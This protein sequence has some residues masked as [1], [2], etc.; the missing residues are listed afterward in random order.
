MHQVESIVNV[1]ASLPDPEERALSANQL[2][3][4]GRRPI[5]PM[6]TIEAICED[7]ARAG[8]V[9]V[10]V[11][12]FMRSY[13]WNPDY[14]WALASPDGEHEAIPVPL[15]SREFVLC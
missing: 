10:E 11:S 1:L 9:E 5:V 7:M 8:M 3:V 14:L 4:R 2:Y 6:R 12:G 13:R 15:T